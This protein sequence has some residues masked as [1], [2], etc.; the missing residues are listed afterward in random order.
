MAQEKKDWIK[1][2]NDLLGEYY[3]QHYKDREKENYYYKDPNKNGLFAYFCDEN[4]FEESSMVYDEFKGEDG[5]TIPVTEFDPNDF[6]LAD[7]DEHENS[8]FDDNDDNKKDDEKPETRRKRR[9]Y[10]LLVYIIENEELPKEIKVVKRQ[11]LRIDLD[12]NQSEVQRITEDIFKKQLTCLA[13]LG[14]NEPGM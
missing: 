4:G 10:K 14:T 2:L 12:I 8:P 13:Q 11:K 9:I 3:K 7:F 6:L 5:N 1:I